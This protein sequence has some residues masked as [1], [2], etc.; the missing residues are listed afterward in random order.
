MLAK[1]R[2]TNSIVTYIYIRN[3]MCYYAHMVY[4]KIN[5]EEHARCLKYF[6]LFIQTSLNVLLNQDFGVYKYMVTY[7]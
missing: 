4:T 3:N 6:L 7:I 1:K 5:F 2:N